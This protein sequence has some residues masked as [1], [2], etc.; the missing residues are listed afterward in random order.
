[1]LTDMGK[2]IHWVFL[3][4]WPVENAFRELNIYGS[5]CKAHY[6]MLKKDSETV[7]RFVDEESK[8]YPLRKFSPLELKFPASL[9]NEVQV[10]IALLIFEMNRELNPQ[11][12]LIYYSFDGSN[13]CREKDT[14]TDVCFISFP[15]CPLHPTDQ[16]YVC[17]SLGPHVT[18]LTRFSTAY[19]VAITEGDIAFNLNGSF[20]TM[21]NEIPPEDLTPFLTILKHEILHALGFHHVE[22]GVMKASFKAIDTLN[23]KEL[24]NVAPD[25]I[26]SWNCIADS[27]FSNRIPF[28]AMRVPEGYY[29]QLEFK[30]HKTD[31]R[32]ILKDLKRHPYFK[33]MF[34][35]NLHSYYYANSPEE[36][37]AEDFQGEQ[38]QPAF[39]H[40]RWEGEFIC[41]VE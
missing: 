13:H 23:N 24:R 3:S 19:S 1:M 40:S 9:K 2:F 31:Q 39:D 22:T 32:A 11:T 33:K 41:G 21:D 25:Q 16:L 15:K 30:P 38:L 18:A 6:G 28:L 8:K 4:L 10:A 29:E 34:D 14:I 27:L 36:R 17:T 20:W 7:F 37:A 26:N 35:F 5:V 12:N